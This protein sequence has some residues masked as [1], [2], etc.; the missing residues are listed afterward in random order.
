MGTPIPA[1]N[2]DHRI[3]KIHGLHQL[4]ESGSGSRLAIVIEL[5]MANTL[6]SNAPRRDIVRCVAYTF[7]RFKKRLNVGI[8]L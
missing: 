8:G 1:C 5:L 7:V 6:T 4:Q 2:H 3:P